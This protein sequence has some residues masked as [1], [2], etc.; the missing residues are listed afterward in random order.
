VR[1]GHLDES[2]CYH[3]TFVPSI[4]QTFAFRTLESP[5]PKPAVATLP[6]KLYIFASV[7]LVPGVVTQSGSILQAW[8]LG[9]LRGF[10][11][12]YLGFCEPGT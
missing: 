2:R 6:P 5:P 11:F 1:C 7:G 3:S 12:W 9:F 4:S 8:D 10:G